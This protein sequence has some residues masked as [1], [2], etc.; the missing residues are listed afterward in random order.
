MYTFVQR[1][2]DRLEENKIGN[3]SKSRSKV[4]IGGTKHAV[5]AEIFHYFNFLL[6][7]H[8][9]YSNDAKIATKIKLKLIATTKIK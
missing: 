7:K 8:Q 6:I 5:F 2:N 1:I 9:F 4:R 3:H